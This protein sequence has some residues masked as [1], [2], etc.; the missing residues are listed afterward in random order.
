[1]SD[2]FKAPFHLRAHY[3]RLS[4]EHIQRIVYAGA[5]LKSMHRKADVLLDRFCDGDTNTQKFDY[6]KV[7]NA[8]TIAEVEAG[9]IAPVFGF[10]DHFDY[11]EQSASLPV[12][13]KIAVPTFVLNAGDDPF[14]STTFFPWILDSEKGGTAPVKLVKTE[15]GGGH[16]GHMFHQ[17]DEKEKKQFNGEYPV[18]S[19]ALSELGRFIRH[20]HTHN[21]TS[22]KN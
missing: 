14:F 3:K 6:W 2:N 10:K 5:L 18:S 7:K 17:F 15:E 12:I 20:V 4:D 9:L 19:F 21:N 13:D 1:M 16:L 11:Y 8:T 22:T